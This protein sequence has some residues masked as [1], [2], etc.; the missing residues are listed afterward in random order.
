M[1]LAQKMLKNNGVALAGSGANNVDNDNQQGGHSS[2]SDTADDE[3]K[4]GLDGAA[5]PGAVNLD[6][7]KEGSA[8]AGA[9]APAGNNE[10]GGGSSASEIVLTPEQLI[11][12]LRKVGVEVNSLSDLKKPAAEVILTEAEKQEAEQKRRNEIRSFALQKGKV[13]TTQ[14]DAYARESTMDSVELAFAVYKRE[15]LAELAE[16]NTPKDEMPS[17]RDMR[18]EFDELNFLY[19]DETDSKRRKALKRLEKEADQYLQE[20]YPSIYDMED[21]FEE[22]VGLQNS[23]AVYNSNINEAFTAIGEEIPFEIKGD[24]AGEVFNYKVKFKPEDVAIIRKMYEG[25]ELFKVLGSANADK[26]VIVEAVKNS[27]L[28]KFLPKILQDVAGAHATAVKMAIQTGRRNIP[29]TTFVD[30]GQAGDKKVTPGVKKMLQNSGV[31]K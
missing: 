24:K 31:K 22:H 20:T 15:K 1:T 18:A 21:E 19:A 30:A 12:E 10:N 25:D 14:L 11:A 8:A 17:D 2:A 16:E 13:S 27:F 23:R 5:N 3:N 4:D 29:I 6:A 26:A 28:S 7:S 9:N